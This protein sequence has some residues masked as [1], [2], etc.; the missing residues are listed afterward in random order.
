MRILNTLLFILLLTLSSF[1]HRTEA[2]SI[3]E[4]HRYELIVRNSLK[5]PLKIIKFEIEDRGINE[6]GLKNV[7]YQF[8]AK[9]K[10]QSRRD[11]LSYKL[12]LKEYVPFQSEEFKEIILT[13]TKKIKPRKKDIAFQERM[14]NHHLETLYVVS[15]AEVLF[16]DGTVWSQENG[17]VKPSQ[18]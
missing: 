12:I 7:A 15:V 18:P 3:I 5:A 13:S 16:E 9:V 14:I 11:I 8:K 17:I 10:N 4:K 1:S 6:L 2:K